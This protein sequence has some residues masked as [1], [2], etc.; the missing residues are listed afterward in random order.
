MYETEANHRTEPLAQVPNEIV[1]KFRESRP[2]LLSRSV[3]PWSEHC[4]ECVWPTCYSSCDLY[5]PRED[6]RCRRFLD[7]MV[8]LDCPGT[9]NSYLL[10][11]RFKRWGK[12]WS[13]GNVCMLPI[14]ESDR[15]EKRDRTIGSVLHQLPIPAPVRNFATGKRYSWKKRIAAG[16]RATSVMPNLFVV[17]CYNPGGHPLSL[18]LTMR[19]TGTESAIPFQRLFDVPSGFHRECVPVEEI[20]RILNLQQPFTVDL[21]PNDIADGATLY[22]GL[23]DFVIADATLVPKPKQQDRVKCIIWDLDNTMWD[24]IL[25]E[26]GSEKLAL[27]PG[28]ADVIRKLDRRGILHSIASKNNFDE[29]IECLK[30]KGVAE[31]FLHPQISWNPKSE[32]LKTIA[33]KLNI[34]ID[35]LMF[36]DDSQFEL[37]EVRSACPE[38]RTLLADRYLELP[39]LPECKGK[40]TE[41]SANRR[42]MY[43][44]EAVRECAAESSAGD[45][46]NFLRDCR[47]ELEIEPV[48]AANLE[49]VHELTQRTN[50]MNFSGSRYE[51]ALL[52]KIAATP[53]L[54]TYVISCRDRFGS[55]GIVGFSIV[56]S[57]EPRMTDLA[58]SC[59]I[60]AKRVEHAFLAHLLKKYTRD[61]AR[62]FLANYRKTPRNAP[63]GQVFADLNMEEDRRARRSYG[64]G[65]SQK[66]DD[67]GRRHYPDRGNPGAGRSGNPVSIRRALGAIRARTISAF[68][69]REF[70]LR[71]DMPTVSFTFDD[72]PRSALQV[73]GAILKSYGARGTYYAA[74]GLMDKVNDLGE[75]FSARD[76]RDLLD[77]GH[78]LGSHT[79][80]HVSCRGLGI[81]DIE[82]EVRKGREAVEQITGAR[83]AHQ[84]SYPYGHAT[85][86]AKTNVG[87]MASTCRGILP[88]INQSLTDLYLLRANSLYS[89]SFDMGAIAQLLEFHGTSGGWVIFY[90]HDVSHNPSAFGCKP[91]EFEKVVRMATRSA[92]ILTIGG[93]ISDTSVSQ[94]ELQSSSLSSCISSDTME[95][96]DSIP[97]F[98]GKND[99]DEHSRSPLITLN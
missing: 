65:I 2:K 19:P 58:F 69:R 44:E 72:F 84:F 20:K 80:S 3:L 92:K 11:I 94:S 17:E 74:M 60:Q 89:Q 76:L 93:V 23:L 53:H 16:S 25:V 54:D 59:R 31:Y 56:D 34:G 71:G 30:S 57:R 83:A 91:A 5:A 43:Q 96:P 51:R 85:M 95:S 46:L 32:A 99:S 1:E 67:P 62:D 97:A 8:R 78:E 21:T 90:T 77:E 98:S 86:R 63:S 13:P 28:I 22:F 10:K 82:A 70:R 50:Q 66:P 52:E 9:A 24:G 47:I 81:R 38:V 4:T 68:G 55:Y 15:I 41:E 40:E 37:A 49:R 79:F 35:T 75:H 39:S 12:L 29:A 88:G 87:R 36:V 33:R 42:K 7:G 14:E 18:S 64:V 73:G 27:K 26:D 61:G 45:Y 48:T 6:G